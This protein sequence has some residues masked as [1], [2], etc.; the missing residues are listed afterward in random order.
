MKALHR[1]GLECEITGQKPAEIHHVISRGQSGDDVPENLV[2][3]ERGLHAKITAEDECARMM[4]GDHLLLNRFDVILYVRQ[5]LGEEAG[6]EW[7]RR[8]LFIQ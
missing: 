3:L 2:T 8:R 1:R 7:L 4:L 5:K 6:A